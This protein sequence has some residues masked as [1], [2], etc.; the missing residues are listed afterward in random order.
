LE[1]DESMIDRAEE[2]GGEHT[3]GKTRERETW[4]S[5][6]GMGGGVRGERTVVKFGVDRGRGERRRVG[7]DAR[8]QVL[9][10]EG[11]VSPRRR[12]EY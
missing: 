4:V 12:N 9:G 10:Q 6:E 3:A 8:C 7:R 2:L 11:L 5:E 1:T